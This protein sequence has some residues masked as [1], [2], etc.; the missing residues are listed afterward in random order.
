M[1]NSYY[2]ETKTFTHDNHE[3]SYMHNMQ[4]FTVVSQELWGV[5]LSH[6]K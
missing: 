2:G 1:S 6:F 5:W 3:I 4:E